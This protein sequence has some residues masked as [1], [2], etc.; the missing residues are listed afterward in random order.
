MCHGRKSSGHNCPHC[1]QRVNEKTPVVDH[2]A[3]PAELR[4]KVLMANTPSELRESLI[5]RLDLSETLFDSSS[6][7][8]PSKGI[9][10]LRKSLD[11]DGK[12]T[13]DAV[14]LSFK[15]Q[16]YEDEVSNFLEMAEAQGTILRLAEGIWQFLE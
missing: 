5:S 13:I 10:V 4:I 11:E 7:F 8:S 2:A 3:N 1:G 14:K 16:G 15:L 12:F 9:S 6:S